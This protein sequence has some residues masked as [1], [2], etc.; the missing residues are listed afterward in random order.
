MR[1]FL[2]ILLALSPIFAQAQRGVFRVESSLWSYEPARAS[3]LP[4]YTAHVI[5][6][7]VPVGALIPKAMAPVGGLQTAAQLNGLFSFTQENSLRHNTM[8]DNYRTA[9]A[10]RLAQESSNGG[11]TAPTTPTETPTPAPPGPA[12]DWQKFS[13]CADRAL[14]LIK[15]AIYLGDRVT[16]VTD[17]E[18]DRAN[19]ALTQVEAALANDRGPAGLVCG[20]SLGAA[21]QIVAN[22]L[23]FNVKVLSSFVRRSGAEREQL[24]EALVAAFHPETDAD[25]SNTW[26]TFW[27]S[28]ALQAVF[29]T[30]PL[31]S[32]DVLGADRIRALNQVQ[33]LSSEA[34]A[35]RVQ[36]LNVETKIN[37]DLTEGLAKA[38]RILGR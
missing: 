4:G 26:K 3:Y 18:R 29:R 36:F 2:F 28:L 38:R 5:S 11:A 21:A 32:F 30:T 15:L 22:D 35:P 20:Q 37:R 7:G 33:N 13:E 17:V 34:D 9:Q 10:A 31:P 24:L 27:A 8:V 1:Y 16:R 12:V 25:A 23:A 19:L 14:P 6:S